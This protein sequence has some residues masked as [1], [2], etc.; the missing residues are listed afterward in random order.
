[1]S[2]KEADMRFPVVLHTDDDVRFGVTVSAL[3]FSV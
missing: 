1:M 3:L 2:E